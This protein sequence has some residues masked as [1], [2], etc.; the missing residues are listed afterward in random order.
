M[1]S[2]ASLASSKGNRSQITSM[3]TATGAFKLATMRRDSSPYQK[4]STS[5]TGTNGLSPRSEVATVWRRSDEKQPL[6]SSIGSIPPSLTSSARPTTDKQKTLSSSS[7]MQNPLSSANHQQISASAPGQHPHKNVTFDPNIKDNSQSSLSSKASSSSAA[8]DDEPTEEELL[9]Q[10]IHLARRLSADNPR[11]EFNW[12]E[13]EDDTWNNISGSSAFFPNSDSKFNNTSSLTSSSNSNNQ[14]SSGNTPFATHGN[15]SNSQDSSSSS[16]I[17]SSATIKRYDQLPK[18]NNVNNNT[19]PSSGSSTSSASAVSTTQI[20]NTWKIPQPTHNVISI[21]KQFQELTEQRN[22]QH[23]TSHSSHNNNNN[24][25]YNNNIGHHHPSEFINWNNPRGPD[26]NYSHSYSH[27][28]SQPNYQNDNNIDT[29]YR[30]SD[31]EKRYRPENPSPNKPELFNE[32]N[33]Q[34]EAYNHRNR[35]TSVSVGGRIGGG[36]LPHN[37]THNANNNSISDLGPDN[38]LET[39]ERRHS[40]FNNQDNNNNNIINNNDNNNNSASDNYNDPAS[41][42]N[43]HPPIQQSPNDSESRDYFMGYRRGVPESPPTAGASNNTSRRYQPPINEQS[44]SNT[45]PQPYRPQRT[46][47]EEQEEFMRVARENALKRKE[48]EARLERE[49]E[50]AAKRKAEERLAK[51]EAKKVQDQQQ[52][53]IQN[54]SQQQ[55]HQ[56]HPQQKSLHADNQSRQPP[57]TQQHQSIFVQ[58]SQNHSQHQ[59]QH[60]NQQSHYIRRGDEDIGKRILQPQSR[61]GPTNIYIQTKGRRGSGFNSEDNPAIRAVNSLIGED[62]NQIRSGNPKIWTGTSSGPAGT[63]TTGSNN[64]SSASLSSASGIPS[65]HN[66][67]IHNNNHNNNNS[68]G[69]NTNANNINN[70]NNPNG[71]NT[72]SVN[73]HNNNGREVFWGSTHAP[74]RSATDGDVWGPFPSGHQHLPGNVYSSTS[75]MSQS[76]SPADH[77]SEFGQQAL[78][79]STPAS[80]THSHHMLPSWINNGTPSAQHSENPPFDTTNHVMSVNADSNGHIIPTDQNSWAQS[81]SHRA[82][83]SNHQSQRSVSLPSSP[84]S[85]IHPN[86]QPHSSS[87]TNSTNNSTTKLVNRSSGLHDTPSMSRGISRFFPV[88]GSEE[89]D[90][91]Q[92]HHHQQQQN[93]QMSPVASSTNIS[94]NNTTPPSAVNHISSPIS[95][96][97]VPS[98]SGLSPQHQQLQSQ[99]MMVQPSMANT[100]TGIHHT[101]P[102]N[103]ITSSSPRGNRPTG[104][105]AAPTTIVSMHSPHRSVVVSS[106][107]GSYMSSLMFT[108][109]PLNEGYTNNIVVPHNNE[110]IAASDYSRSI[111]GV[112][113]ISGSNSVALSPRI[114]LPPSNSTFNS[115]DTSRST[116]PPQAQQSPF[117]T[118]PSINSI[119]ALQTTIA[120]KLGGKTKPAT[121]SFGVIPGSQNT[122]QNQNSL[123]SVSRDLPIPVSPIVLSENIPSFISSD[124]KKATPIQKV[125]SPQ[126]PNQDGIYT[127]VVRDDQKSI[128]GPRQNEAEVPKNKT[129][130]E[131]NRE[132]LTDPPLRKPQ[133]FADAVALSLEAEK[134]RQVAAATHGIK[135]PQNQ[136]QSQAQTQVAHNDQHE[137]EDINYIL[138]LNPQSEIAIFDESI[139]EYFDQLDGAHGGSVPIA[140]PYYNSSRYN[141]ELAILNKDIEIPEDWDKGLIIP[142]DEFLCTLFFWS[143]QQATAYNREFKPR[144]NSRVALLIPGNTQK[145][146]TTYRINNTSILASAT[147]NGT[148][149]NELIE[150]KTTKSPPGSSDSDKITSISSPSTAAKSTSGPSK[151]GSDTGIDGSNKSIFTGPE[152]NSILKS[153]ASHSLH[154]TN[155]GTTLPATGIKRSASSTLSG[156]SFGRTP[157]RSTSHSNH[158]SSSTRPSK[159]G[160]GATSTSVSGSTTKQT[161]TSP[162]SSEHV[163]ARVRAQ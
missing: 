62:G 153:S 57:F 120:E 84:M 111:P 33:G 138:Q 67:N 77:R 152:K 8:T 56:Q 37:N 63:S 45:N 42:T 94:N 59:H 131:P 43:I 83:S 53:N 91:Q 102:S 136:P 163:P 130:T 93:Q 17:A 112:P 86:P 122:S 58:N 123:D 106:D 69:H 125:F 99:S 114:S 115:D 104:P 49:R 117:K 34:V 159:R 27:S 160:P 113:V 19:M 66:G 28:H 161:S 79:T 124:Q 157:R 116:H 26:N 96:T 156:P 52:L 110:T 24:N 16:P 133:S 92:Q 30:Y 4:S 78:P 129:Q 13:E 75:S 97:T 20:H 148:S 14:Q 127:Y 38:A 70:D 119:Q 41:Q 25:N 139:Q 82:S 145:V 149:L 162:S 128:A 151:K 142:R 154:S 60:Y 89:K 132:I 2:Y 68:N 76:A 50:E 35:N 23:H 72:P 80:A 126:A 158:R 6:P 11:R 55:Q 90:H 36:A 5:S 100:R 121:P 64:T 65:T 143:E 31:Y 9:R 39:Y 47:L 51:L 109:L 88:V 71:T 12:D 21:S 48:E 144:T 54:G 61:N 46:F 73:G 32:H 22:Q 18:P 44:P 1:G 137:N 40:A 15:I 140:M 155:F 3:S 118:T 107:D 101:S 103:N 74:S 150:G 135:K 81:H 29:R 10:G 141:P 7:L 98:S 95:A 147:S 146:L 85:S 105:S 87:E 134:R 108:S